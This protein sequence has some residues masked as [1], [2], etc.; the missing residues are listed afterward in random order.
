MRTHL[1]P[2]CHEWVTYQDDDRYEHG[3]KP[4]CDGAQV[5][6]CPAGWRHLPA[7][8]LVADEGEAA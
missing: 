6:D 7:C 4:G 3:H 1:C 2:D 8:P 5:C